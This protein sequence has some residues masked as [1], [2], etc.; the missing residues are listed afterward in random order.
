ML[1]VP[2][3]GVRPYFGDPELAAKGVIVLE[4]GIHGIPVNMAKDVYDDLAAGALGGYWPVSYTH[5][6]TLRSSGG[7]PSRAC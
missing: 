4:I 3:A 6:S 1:K 7:R 2:G 5:L